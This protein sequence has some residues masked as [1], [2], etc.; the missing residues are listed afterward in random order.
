LNCEFSPLLAELILPLLPPDLIRKSL[1]FEP[2]TLNLGLESKP[3]LTS[4]ELSCDN[5]DLDPTLA[6]LFMSTPS[7]RLESLSREHAELFLELLQLDFLD[8]EGS[9]RSSLKL[10]SDL[11]EPCGFV[12]GISFP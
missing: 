3:L 2:R 8:K 10:P 11:F 12:V 1:S 6:F 7:P 9:Q 4:P 5:F